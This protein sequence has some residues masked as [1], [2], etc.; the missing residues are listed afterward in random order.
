MLSL[1]IAL[2]FA[3]STTTPFISAIPTSVCPTQCLCD[4]S[5]TN[6]Y[7]IS[8]PTFSNLGNN[9]DLPNPAGTMIASTLAIIVKN[10]N[11]VSYPTNLCAYASTLQSLDLS[12]NQISLNFPASYLSC[13]TNLRYVYLYNNKIPSIDANAF[14]NNINLLTIDLSRNRLTS[15]PSTLFPST[16]TRLLTIN[17][18]NNLLTSLDTWFFYLPSIDTIDLSNNLISGFANT[19]GFTLANQNSLPSFLSKVIV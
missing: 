7:T 14:Q 6:E 9:I 12:T 8:C 17:L 10:A 4:Y 2:I 3:L 11:L 18:N 16:L 1:I 19:L 15:I 13:L 5:I